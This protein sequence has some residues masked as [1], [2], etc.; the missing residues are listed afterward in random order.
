MKRVLR[1]PIN[2]LLV[3]AIAGTL[4]ACNDK[5]SPTPPPEYTGSEVVQHVLENTKS[6]QTVRLRGNAQ[7]YNPHYDCN[8][9]ATVTVEL[10][11]A[12]S[13]LAAKAEVKFDT[14]VGNVIVKD[15]RCYYYRDGKLFFPAIDENGKVIEG[16]FV[17]FSLPLSNGDVEDMLEDVLDETLDE[18]NGSDEDEI[19]HPQDG[20]YALHGAV[21]VAPQLNAAKDVLLQIKDAQIAE[22][23]PGVAPEEYTR[24]QLLSD[25]DAIFESELVVNLINNLN[26]TFTHIGLPITAENV[27]NA[28]CVAADIS[29]QDLCDMIREQSPL[30]PSP[31][32][33]EQPY[34]YL[35]RVGAGL[36]K[37]D[38]LL[39]KI[40]KKSRDELK[41]EVLAFL[42]DEN[43]TIG[44]VFDLLCE[45]ADAKLRP[46]LR[47]LG[48]TPPA[49][50]VLSMAV[51]QNLTL[52]SCKSDFSLRVDAAALRI[53]GLSFTL[54]LA[55][56]SGAQ[57]RKVYCAFDGT[58]EY[59]VTVNTTLPL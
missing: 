1:V 44:T 4:F 11:K 54:D 53:S 14:T 28:A 55:W 49:S 24:A 46:L 41:T 22:F 57:P 18:S 52:S 35:M 56:Q 48:I 32:P 16:S 37:V 6:A 2:I 38:T 47:L 26:E 29:T 50:P 15:T 43:N 51:L 3:L 39:K 19:L 31:L 27:V 40:T 5:T 33:S 13:G 9:P 23:M 10:E 21:D 12:V 8:L 7:V 58:A 36:V 30:F 17:A 45:K 59:D 34:T 42:D 25:L 20:V